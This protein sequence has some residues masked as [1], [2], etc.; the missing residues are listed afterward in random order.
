MLE[1]QR[2]IAMVFKGTAAAALAVALAACAGNKV[3]NT[4]L[5][6]PAGSQWTAA[7]G[8]LIHI[9]A[10]LGDDFT[11]SRAGADYAAE[12]PLLGCTAQAA[13]VQLNPEE[14]ASGLAYAVYRL[15]FNSAQPTLSFAWDGDGPAAQQGWIGFSNWQTQR[16]D[17]VRLSNRASIGLGAASP[18]KDEQARC[19][20][21]VLLHGGTA[22][23][24]AS[25][26]FPPPPPPPPDLTYAIVDTAQSTAYSD[27]GSVINP[28]PGQTFYGQDAHYDGFQPGFTDNGNGTVTDN[29]TGLMWQQ[30]LPASGKLGSDAALAYAAGLTLG[31][32]DDW[33]LPTIKELYSLIDFRGRTGM[34]LGNSVPFIDTNYFEFEYGNEAA[35]E[36][37]IDAQF[38]SSTGYVSTTMMGDV[39]VFGVN[40][41][42][43][44]IK[45]YPMTMPGPGGGA[46]LCWARCVRGNPDYGINSFVDNGDGT[47]SDEATGLMW[48]K[49]DSAALSAGPRN[50]GLLNWEEAL[51]WAEGLS[52]AGHDDWRLPNVKEL[53]SLT[54]YS[55]APD[56]G[57]PAISDLFTS[58]SYV[59]G[60][61]ATDW[62]PY[63]SGTTHYEVGS[64]G[65][66]A[67]YVNFGRSL[68]WMQMPPPNGPW[69]LLDVHGAGAQRSDPKSG[70]P[71]SYPHGNGPQG[72]VI[73]IYNLVRCVR[74][75]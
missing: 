46:M 30:A 75:F 58:T 9:T 26:G 53:H 37:L 20:V 22:R 4:E 25:I 62:Y 18:Y 1:W 57:G 73:G 21:A 45:G 55:R 38:W 60:N 27:T 6:T 11:E 31:G 36:R 66:Y 71:A 40:F 23:T 35:G 33:R 50:D 47:I 63:W 5:P 72:D 42:D 41:A 67:S 61:G 10:A 39:T 59:N 24:L 29:V 48:L 74:D 19:L 43:G 51:A 3:D 2:V 49:D 69:T 68:G 15:R 16:W 70:D 32:H 56:T 65:S 7:L 34:T 64:G 13:H 8:S 12:L 52:H 54:D 14:D 17:W 44:R 28:A